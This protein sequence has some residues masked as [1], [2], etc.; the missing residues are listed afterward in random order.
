M[1]KGQ[2][3]ETYWMWNT[4]RAPRQLETQV[5]RP[6]EVQTQMN[7]RDIWSQRVFRVI[8]KEWDLKEKAEEN[9]DKNIKKKT[10]K[11]GKKN[12]RYKSR[13]EFQKER[14]GNLCQ[15][16]H[17][18]FPLVGLCEEI[19]QELKGESGIMVKIWAYL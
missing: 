17:W 2:E 3:G 10:D 14:C 7:I 8:K 13:K 1:V 12:V 4:S 6:E 11:S 15:T 19:W 18:I 9:L 5:W 16:L